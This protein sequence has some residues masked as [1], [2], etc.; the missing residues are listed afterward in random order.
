MAVLSGQAPGTFRK[1]YVIFI[2]DIGVNKGE[3][4]SD[5][6]PTVL[7]DKSLSRV[8]ILAIGVYQHAE[9]TA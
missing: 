5:C 1:L 4:S 7:S 6:S 8:S 3:Y 2:T 9:I